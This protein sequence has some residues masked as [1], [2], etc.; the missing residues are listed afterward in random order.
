MH[1]LALLPSSRLGE[2]Q[3][4]LGKN[5]LSGRVAAVTDALRQVKWIP[6]TA[7]SSQQQ[8][9]VWH[10]VNSILTTKT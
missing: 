5:L 8:Q 6:G 9:P 10:M 2:A 7:S 4:G 1:L 3:A